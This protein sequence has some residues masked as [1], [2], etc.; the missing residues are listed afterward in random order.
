MEVRD[1]GVDDLESKAW[2]DEK[3]GFA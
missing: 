2:A 1:H 3:T